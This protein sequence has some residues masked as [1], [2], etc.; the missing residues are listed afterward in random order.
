MR[1]CLGGNGQPLERRARLDPPGWT[2]KESSSARE[3]F[4]AVANSLPGTKNIWY[5]ELISF[6]Q[7][8]WIR[9]GS[10]STTIDLK[11]TTRG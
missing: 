10:R 9:G 5:W 11:S 4:L 3:S 8:H 1:R 6:K 7:N 2:N